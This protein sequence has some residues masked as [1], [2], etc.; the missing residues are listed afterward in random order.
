MMSALAIGTAEFVIMGNLENVAADLH[1]SLSAAGLLVSGYALGV[2][3]GGP[4]I[5]TI[6]GRVERKTLLLART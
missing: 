4:V 2:A 6:T 1:V 3:I 5:T